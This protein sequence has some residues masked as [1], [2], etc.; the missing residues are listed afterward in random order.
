MARNL[1]RHQSS[2]MVAR[3]E[4]GHQ[5][6]TSPSSPPEK[7]AT[8]DADSVPRLDTQRT[9]RFMAS[10]MPLKGRESLMLQPLGLPIQNIW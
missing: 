10:H 9:L 8:K 1:N 4:I 3:Q 5:A 2:D 6:V 7:M